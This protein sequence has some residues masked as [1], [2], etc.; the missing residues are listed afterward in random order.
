MHSIRARHDSVSWNLTG[1]IEVA[2]GLIF[3]SNHY[4]MLVWIEL[5]E[6]GI[7]ASCIEQV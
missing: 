7:L 2:P 6:C 3:S 1:Y 5:T 4:E